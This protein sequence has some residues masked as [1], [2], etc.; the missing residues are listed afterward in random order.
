MLIYVSVSGLSFVFQKGTTV[1][2]GQLFHTLPVRHREFQ[3][4][5]KK[6]FSKLVHVLD[7]YCIISTGVRI[8]C[9]NQVGKG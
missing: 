1:S 9:T 4:N 5:V 6:E 7:G 2:L 3:R 8:S